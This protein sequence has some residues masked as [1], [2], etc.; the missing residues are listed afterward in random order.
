MNATTSSLHFSLEYAMAF[1]V[2]QLDHVEVYVRDLEQALAWYQQTLGLLEVRRWEPEPIMIG[3]GDTYLAL[4][5]AR[6]GLPGIQ[7]TRAIQPPY[8]WHRVAWRVS[9]SGL[10]EAIHH[11]KSHGVALRGPIDHVGAVSI[12]FTDPDG[13]P[14]EITTYEP[15]DVQELE[16]VL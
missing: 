8:R 13:N 6:S 12:Y 15:V 2:S 1:A 3:A 5:Q 14:L 16:R 4:F 10:L 11:L 7:G 9:A